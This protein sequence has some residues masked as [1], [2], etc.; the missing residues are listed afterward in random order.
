MLLR[1]AVIYFNVILAA[2]LSVGN[3]ALA[4]SKVVNVGVLAHR[5]S[6]VCISIWN[7]TINY[8]TERIQGYEFELLPLD[9]DGVSEAVEQGKVGFI[10]TN[11]GNYVDLES[12]YGITRVATLRNLR[13]GKPYTVFGSVIFVR[14]DHDGLRT[15]A[16]L[17]NHSF[18]AVDLAAF[19][20]FQ[21]AWREL[22]EAG[23]NPFGDFSEI[24]FLGFPQDNIV[25]G[26]R[27]GTI[28]AGTV[29]TD[30]LERMVADDRIRLE[31]FRILN[32][33]TSSDFPF[34]LSSRLYPEWAFAKTRSTPDL[35]AEKVAIALLNMAEN[36]PAAVSGNYAGWTVPL[37]YQPVHEL[38]MDLQIGPYGKIGNISLL[39]LMRQYWHWLLLF[40]AII[41]LTIFHNLL[42]NRQVALR[43]RELSSVN[44]ALEKEVI[45]RR[46]AERE[47]RELVDEKRFLAQKCMQVQEDE[48]HHLARELHD[49]LG[50]CITAIQADAETIQELSQKY[51]ARLATS[52]QAIENVSSRIYEVVHSMMQ[53]LRPS[54]LDDIG[55]T[56]TL[57]EEVQ[58]WQARQPDINYTLN[59]AGELNNLSDN[60]NITLFRIVQECLTNI[61][62]HAGATEVV[63]D[64]E[65]FDDEQIPLISLRVRDNGVGMTQHSI[66]SGFGLIG[67]RERAEALNGKVEFE[68]AEGFGTTVSVT[69]PLARSQETVPG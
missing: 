39:E 7:P 9:L 15:L 67:M 46:K 52:A 23:I 31:D 10:L 63:I 57:E 14:A 30:I 37:N 49:E 38:F 19:G 33:K 45:E 26:V 41:M 6:D 44:G 53:R 50:Q 25:L 58:A 3:V 1:L 2:C 65:H 35:L 43:T 60:V 24:Q 55:L 17:K 20:G 18:G 4:D 12:Q 27:D 62:K 11:P 29:R 61:A 8:L 56:A 42:V 34:Q 48:R 64:L 54:A 28:D 22:K 21:M 32:Q 5:G 69:L 68:T 16:D 13:Q 66:G 59:L 36:H 47:A 40:A 51:D